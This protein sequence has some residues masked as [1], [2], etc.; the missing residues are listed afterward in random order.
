MLGTVNIMTYIIG[1]ICIVLIPGPN[2]LYVLSVATRRGARSG[3]Q[4]AM[5]IYA[6]DSILMILS[7]AGITSVMQTYPVLFHL[8]KY[9]GAVYLGYLGFRM[10]WS[11]IRRIHSATA[12]APLTAADTAQPFIKSL[13]ISLLNPKAILFFIAFFTQFVDPAYPYP[14][15]SFTLLG[16]ILQ[17]CS[18]TYLTFLI[19]VGSKMAERVQQT[20]KFTQLFKAVTGTLFIGFGV[21]LALAT[22]G[23]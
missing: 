15:L 7:A 4:G 19:L 16:L 5:G 11:V 21:R 9:A 2:S 14:A 3:F 6:G 13:V 23:T 1:T 12:A 18:V 22:I 8:I 20:K 17:A 10:L